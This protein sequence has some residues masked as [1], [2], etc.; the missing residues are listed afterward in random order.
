MIRFDDVTKKYEGQKKAVFSHFNEEIGAGEFIALTGK[1]GSGKT[2]LLKMLLRM[3]EPT[4]GRIFVKGEE[5]GRIRNRR[6]PH[7]R[8]GIGVVFQD[9]MLFKDRS[10]YDNLL[11]AYRITNGHDSGSEKRIGDVLTFLGLDRLYKRMPSQISGGEQQKVCLAR[12]ILNHPRLLLADEPT[13]NLDP[14]AS[15][16]VMQLF[17]LIHRQGVTVVLA[18]HDIDTLHREARSFRTISLDRGARKGKA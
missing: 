7:Y 14:D 9:F 11:L 15:A 13:G 6:V 12:A 10:V 16:E 3:T 1:S 2:T 4:K 18:T 8:R 17:E 5:I